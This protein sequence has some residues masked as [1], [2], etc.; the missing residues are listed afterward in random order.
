MPASQ[1]DVAPDGSPVA[2]YL[3]LPAEP[4]FTPVLDAI[5]APATVLDLGCG[6][7]R[8]ANTL[9]ARGSWV[10]GVDESAAMLAHLHHDV[11]RVEG[12]LERLHLAASSTSWSSPATRST[13]R[14]RRC[15]GRPWRP[16]HATSGLPAAFRP[17]LEP[18]GRTRRPRCPSGRRP[19]RLP[20]PGP[21]RRGVRRPGDLHDRG[22]VVDADLHGHRPRRRRA[23][24]RPRPGPSSPPAAR[25][26][27]ARRRA[28]PGGERPIGQPQAGI[29]APAYTMA[30]AVRLSSEHKPQRES[31][32]ARAVCTQSGTVGRH[33]EGRSCA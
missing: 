12:R 10:T 30:V 13:S 23:R 5:A 16:R 31:E 28:N 7:G 8:L 27:M 2:V 3:W 29:S 14:A 21:A 1:P 33:G 22:A 19:H 6:V 20:D 24:R 25:T 26:D 32:P 17:A 9:A 15:A 11:E 4:E 18:G